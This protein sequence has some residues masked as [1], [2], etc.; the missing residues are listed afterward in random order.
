MPIRYLKIVLVVFVSLLCLLYAAQ[1]VV[2]L[3]AAYG[4]VYAVFSMAD[5]GVYPASLGPAIT[6]PALVWLALAVIIALEFAAGLLAAR[7][8]WD[9]WAAR[10]APAEVFNGAKTWAL[11]GCGLGVVVWF[12]LFTTLG[13][14]WFQMWQTE[15]GSGSLQ[16]AFQYTMQIGLVLLFVNMADR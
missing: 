7:G 6:S 16:G 11:L 4:F 15:L 14:A 3:R 9:L 12:G 1:N 2:N 10:H 8:A 5:H 13:G